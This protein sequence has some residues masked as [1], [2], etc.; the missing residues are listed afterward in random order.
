MG[1]CGVTPA[2]A[3]AR[4]AIEPG[5]FGGSM[6][7]HE[8]YSGTSLYL[9]VQYEGAGFHLG[10]PHFAQGNGETALTALE[11]SLRVNVL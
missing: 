2:G 11:G 4:G 6:D 10:D 7:R 8:I 9:P 5:P 3:A 1:L